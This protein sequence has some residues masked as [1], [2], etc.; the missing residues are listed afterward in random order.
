MILSRLCILFASVFP[1]SQCTHAQTDARERLERRLSE[2]GKNI[3]LR[4][5]ATTNSN[6]NVL[7]IHS[8]PPD[9]THTH[10]HTHRGR[11][12]TPVAEYHLASFSVLACHLV[13]CTRR[14]IQPS[15]PSF[16][17][18]PNQSALRYP[19]E[20]LYM[21]TYIGISVN[22]IRDEDAVR[23]IDFLTVH[24]IRTMGKWK[25]TRTRQ[26]PPK[27]WTKTIKTILLSGMSR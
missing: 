9:L 10:T 26:G 1:P 27:E 18:D 20:R 2:T 22:C 7:N 13:G 25:Y 24:W 11:E 15:E 4:C 17:R 23:I 16:G 12:S 14:Q 8:C 21:R 6:N 5:L 3:H 19:E